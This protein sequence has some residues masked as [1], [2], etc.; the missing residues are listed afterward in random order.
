MADKELIQKRVAEMSRSLLT[1]GYHVVF[2]VTLP[3]SIFHK[4]RHRK[5]GHDITIIGTYSLSR[6]RLYRDGRLRHTETV[7]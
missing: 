1:E 5:N 2:K 6:I 7:K 4:L 3:G